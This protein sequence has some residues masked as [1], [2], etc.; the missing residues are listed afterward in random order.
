MIDINNFFEKQTHI[1]ESGKNIFFSSDSHFGHKN[2]IDFCNRPFKDVEEMNETLINNWNNVVGENDIIYHLGDFAFGGSQLWNSVLD[3]LN[4][5]IHFLP[6]NHDMK[7]LRQGYISKF[8]SVAFQRQIY[9]ENICI[10]LNHYPFLCYGGSYRY[11]NPVWQLFGHVHSKPE[12]YD[13]THIEDNEVKEILGKD[14]HRLKYLLP[15]QYDVGVDNNN[16]TPVSF[17]QVK[18]IIEKQIKANN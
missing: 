18:N 16:Y 2:I 5:H 7:N 3:R 13:I 6:G 14:T 9:I 12:Q 15:T 8:A 17:E 11:D 10:Y 4:G 1:Y